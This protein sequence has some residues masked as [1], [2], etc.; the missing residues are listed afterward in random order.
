MPKSLPS[1]LKAKLQG[2]DFAK[3]LE[4]ISRKESKLPA[5]KRYMLIG[6]AHIAMQQQQQQQQNEQSEQKSV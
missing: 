3:E 4:L 6:L 5:A 1:L 2:I